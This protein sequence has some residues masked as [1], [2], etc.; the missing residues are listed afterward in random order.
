MDKMAIMAVMAWLH[1][2]MNKADIGVY[3]KKQGKCRLAVKAELKNLHRLK[4]YG[5]KKM[6]SEI[7]VIFFVQGVPQYCLHFCFVNFSASKALRSL[8]LDIF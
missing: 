2:A 3:A 4:S 1:M 8:I 7:M 6:D 5:Q